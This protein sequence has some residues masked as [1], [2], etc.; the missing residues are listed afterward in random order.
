VAVTV[1]TG[2]IYP[3]LRFQ[4]TALVSAKGGAHNLGAAFPRQ[5]R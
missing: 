1:L 3:A 4:I 2:E 5:A